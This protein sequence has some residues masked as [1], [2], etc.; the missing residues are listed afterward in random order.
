M[1][2]GRSLGDT[3]LVDIVGTVVRAALVAEE[4]D[5]EE[6]D[7]AE[8]AEVDDPALCVDVLTEMLTVGDWDPHVVAVTTKAAPPT[9]RATS[10][11]AVL[12]KRVFFMAL[13]PE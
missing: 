3:I 5:V 11:N 1:S 13:L 8:P 2:S 10:N 7:G 6:L 4:I 12:E 9:D